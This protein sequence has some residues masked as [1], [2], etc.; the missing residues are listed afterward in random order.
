MKY[1][2]G[3]LILVK[4]IRP[5]LRLP[6]RLRPPLHPHLRPR[7]RPRLH[8]R[9]LNTLGIITEVHKHSDFFR[10]GS[11]EDDNGCIWYSQVNGREYYFY[12][13]EVECEVIK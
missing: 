2:V 11:T 9:L 13:D 6:L 1:K 4:D 5:L 3:D 8:P 12:Q 7:L 10:S